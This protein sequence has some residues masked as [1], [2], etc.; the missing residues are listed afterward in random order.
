V[1]LLLDA[2]KKRACDGQRWSFSGMGTIDRLQGR[3][4]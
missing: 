1:E 2:G 4:G 3:R